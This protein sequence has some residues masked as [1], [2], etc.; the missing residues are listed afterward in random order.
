V[1]LRFPPYSKALREIAEIFVGQLYV[2][3]SQKSDYLFT[4]FGPRL[5]ESMSR[6][7][8]AY[9]TRFR[10]LL[11][12][13][14][15]RRLE[16]G[17]RWLTAKAESQS[18]GQGVPLADALLQLHESLARKPRFAPRSPFP[19]PALFYCDGGLGGLARWLRAAGHDTRWDAR[20]ADDELLKRARELSATILTTDS[21]LMERR[22]LRD[23][24]IPAFWMPPTLS[25]AEQ[26]ALV[27]DE[28]RLQVRERR[29]MSCGGQL[30]R[31]DKEV[32]RDRIPPRTYRWLDEY[33]VCTRC[34]QLF[35][36][37]THWQRIHRQLEAIQSRSLKVKAER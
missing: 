37:G 11:Q 10:W 18:R 14:N 1:T 12:R 29:C 15:A 31:E 21:I 7:L 27:F 8:K 6:I 35:W 30:S 13:V 2:A 20:V 4:R 24:V 17:V 9:E 19:V 16:Q 26:L 28:F 3:P 23:R 5:K 25:I 22:L 33:Y 32:L 36:H 34:G